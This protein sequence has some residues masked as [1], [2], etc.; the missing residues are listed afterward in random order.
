MSSKDSFS[1]I[2]HMDLALRITIGLMLIVAVATYGMARSEIVTIGLLLVAVAVFGIPHGSFDYAVAK[3]SG[4]ISSKRSAILFLSVYVILAAGSFAVWMLYPRVGLVAF[5]ALSVW[6]FSHDWLGRGGLYR[7]AMALLVVF[8]PL[9]IWPDLVLYYF[10]VLMFAESISAIP[11]SIL[12]LGIL[13][14]ILWS[15]A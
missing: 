13:I 15:A 9:V 4:V 7:S 1:G 10:S 2:D 5:L 12:L 14:G 3:K 8:G 6:H 11:Q